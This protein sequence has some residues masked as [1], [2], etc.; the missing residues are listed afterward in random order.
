MTGVAV[1]EAIV[2]QLSEIPRVGRAP[3]RTEDITAKVLRTAGDVRV[4]LVIVERGLFGRVS[5]RVSFPDSFVFQ[6]DAVVWADVVHLPS[7]REGRAV[8]NG[9]MLT[10]DGAARV[11]IPRVSQDPKK[12]SPLLKRGVVAG[13]LYV[14]SDIMGTLVNTI[15]FVSSLASNPG[16]TAA[17]KYSS[18]AALFTGTITIYSACRNLRRAL[19]IGDVAGRVIETIRVV[20]GG[21]EIATGAIVGAF[22]TVTLIASAPGTAAKTVAVAAVPLGISVTAVASILYVLIALPFAIMAVKGIRLI[23]ETGRPVQE[24][25]AALQRRVYLQDEDFLQAKKSISHHSEAEL[26]ALCA[27]DVVLMSEERNVLSEGDRTKIRGVVVG[28]YASQEDVVREHLIKRMEKACAQCKLAKHADYLRASGGESLRYLSAFERGEISTEITTKEMIVRTARKE[29]VK[30]VITYTLIILTAIIGITSFVL[31]TV[32]SGGLVLVI[33]LGLMLAMNLLW[34][35]LDSQGLKAKLEALKTSKTLDK[36]IMFIFLMITI[37]SIAAGAFFSGGLLPLIL[38]L[39]FGAV[40]VAFQGSMLG[41]SIYKSREVV[42]PIRDAPLCHPY[43]GQS[44]E[45]NPL[46]GSEAVPLLGAS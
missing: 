17:L 22:R 28:L 21:V 32:F 23:R 36:V 41:Y 10:I 13:A 46:G 29:A 25:F 35:A 26:K 31:T 18:L 30:A 1:R 33:G 42:K 2:L 3:A 9:V 27:E 24:A 7:G 44:R 16:L 37:L 39:I 19:A 12:P 14:A 8:E 6:R 5:Y 40:S 15:F 11:F 4:P 38:I 20:R 45:P 34:L 43:G